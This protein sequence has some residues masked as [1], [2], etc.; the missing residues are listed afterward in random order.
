[1]PLTQSPVTY[2]NRA[3]QVLAA[4]DTGAED[5]LAEPGLLN[6]GDDILDV[7]LG[8]R[9]TAI[10]RWLFGAMRVPRDCWA[11]PAIAVG[12]GPSLD[13]ML[14]QL[15]ELQ[16]TVPI[17]AAHSAIP[18]LLAAGIVPHVIAPKERSPSKGIVPVDLPASVIYGGLT[19]VPEAPDRCRR[20][21]LVDNCEY[22]NTW[23]GFGGSIDIPM[24][25]G[26]LAAS[27][28]GTFADSVYLAGFDMTCGHYAGYN[29]AQED[30]QRGKV[31][32][33]D[34]VDRP[35][36]LLYQRTQS[37]LD[38][39][40]HDHVVVQCA[41]T[42]A[43]LGGRYALSGRLPPAGSAQVNLPYTTAWGRPDTEAIA[44]VTAKLKRLPQ[45]MGRAECLAAD[46]QDADGLSVAALFPEDE[47][48]GS[49]FQTVYIS[50]SILQRTQ[51]WTKQETAMATRDALLN[52]F[53][54]LRGVW[55]E[56]AN[57]CR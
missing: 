26:T 2:T 20:H 38:A 19:C 43:K 16:S 36:T 24:T 52:A 10:N 46:A 30:G 44:Q 49:I 12:S 14:P 50:M 41:P 42:G 54:G 35:T 45:I 47:L 25:S 21:W 29:L 28:A 39:L 23:L 56:I 11:G 27:I 57:D 51:D 17:V 15:H 31:A 18:K 9:Q 37:M 33:V 4:L 40:A 1:M 32:C 6:H 13:T 34:G 22:F 48:L 3:E 53:S 7:V 5:A 8:I 55:K